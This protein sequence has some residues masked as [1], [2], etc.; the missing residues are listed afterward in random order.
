MILSNI[1]NLRNTLPLYKNYRPINTGIAVF[2]TVMIIGVLSGSLN[3]L[4]TEA[5]AKEYAKLQAAKQAQETDDTKHG[6]NEDKQEQKEMEA[7]IQEAFEDSVSSTFK[8]ADYETKVDLNAHL[9]QASIERTDTSDGFAS[10]YYCGKTTGN[11]VKGFVSK[12]KTLG[13]E[14]KKYKFECYYN[15][16][17]TFQA[18][19]DADASNISVKDD[20]GEIVA[21]GSASWFGHKWEAYLAK[22][23]QDKIDAAA[24]RRAKIISDA[25]TKFREIY[26]AYEKNELRA[27]DKYKDKRFYISAKVNGM[28]TGGLLNIGG[29]ATLTME[30]RVGNTIVFFLAEFEKEQEDALKTID[31]GDTIIFEGTCLSAGAWSDCELY[32]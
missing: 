7:K 25:S 8:G 23:E 18:T 10:K 22:V 13:K 29:G 26:L 30:Y 32:K 17:M 9:I 27:D 28:E 15:G 21:K 6:A 1:F 4:H 24:A 3:G 5:Y 31:V 20:Q 14:I 2:L 12:N 19:V 16:R 11:I